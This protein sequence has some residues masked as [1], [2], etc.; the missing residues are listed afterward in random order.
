M[1]TERHILRSFTTTCLLQYFAG[2]DNAA[3]SKA[4]LKYQQIVG[5]Y[6]TNNKRKDKDMLAFSFESFM[7]MFLFWNIGV[8]QWQK[9][10]RPAPALRLAFSSRFR[11]LVAPSSW[12][13]QKLE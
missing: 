1:F 6:S 9:Q 4:E 12:H 7:R 13:L 3:K 5:D 11:G 2:K 8:S 10:R